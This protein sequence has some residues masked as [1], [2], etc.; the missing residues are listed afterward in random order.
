MDAFEDG[1]IIRSNVSAHAG[2]FVFPSQQV[3]PTTTVNV[4]VTVL[5]DGRT[6]CDAI[7]NSPEKKEETIDLILKDK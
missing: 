3:K 5:E 1:Q 7:I 6:I 4:C 2:I